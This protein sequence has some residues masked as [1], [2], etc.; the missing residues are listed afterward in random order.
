MLEA[1][2][3]SKDSTNDIVAALEYAMAQIESLDRGRGV[4]SIDPLAVID[5]LPRFERLLQA[6]QRAFGVART[7]RDPFATVCV[8]GMVQRLVT[9]V[10]SWDGVDMD[11]W[12]PSQ[13]LD[14]GGTK[15]KSRSIK[16]LVNNLYEEAF[17]M[18][19]ENSVANGEWIANI[20][21]PNTYRLEDGVETASPSFSIASGLVVSKGYM[22]VNQLPESVRSTLF[23]EHE[24]GPSRF[25]IFR[26]WFVGPYGWEQYVANT[27]ST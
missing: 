10:L 15:V 21:R 1:I 8:G 27:G 26:S 22:W 2:D 14:F 17:L 19:L 11:R 23:T 20:D 5:F 25:R 24:Y 9:K 7:R 3:W 6:L 18:Q 13:R 16:K 12:P 4:L